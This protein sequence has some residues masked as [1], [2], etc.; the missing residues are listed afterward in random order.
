[1]I[2]RIELTGINWS[3]KFL[4]NIDLTVNPVGLE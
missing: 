1:M 4:T 3:K 2:G